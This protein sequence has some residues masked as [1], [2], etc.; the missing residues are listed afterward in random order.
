M[1]P[2]WIFI[3]CRVLLGGVFLLACVHKILHPDTF[4]HAIFQYR[5]LPDSLINV[6]AITLP[7]VE[8]F[9]ALAVLF[10]PR[11]KQSGA[12]ILLVLL[13]VF[14][15][16]ISVNILRGLEVEC[17]CFTSAEGAD[18]LGWGHVA[19][20]LGYICL[21]VVVLFENGIRTMSRR[22]GCL[23]RSFNAI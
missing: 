16:A 1:N 10:L 5:L 13:T 2:R 9:A 4:A 19:R 20:N 12:L 6:T 17:G 21:A 11:F 7:W 15:V 23:T 22:G 18:L 8:L 3:G 14:T